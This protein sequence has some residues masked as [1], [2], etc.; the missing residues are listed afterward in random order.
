MPRLPRPGGR[1]DTVISSAI[2]RKAGAATLPGVGSPSPVMK[3]VS[4]LKGRLLATKVSSCLSPC[5]T[6][7]ATLIM[8]RLINY[9]VGLPTLP[10]KLG[11]YRPLSYYGVAMAGGADWPPAAHSAQVLPLWRALPVEQIER[12]PRAVRIS[13]CLV[14]PA[15]FKLGFR[16]T[17]PELQRTVAGMSVNARTLMGR[18]PSCRAPSS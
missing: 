14:P 3:I 12:S 2:C 13:S 15:W 9:T 10:T 1:N 5:I 7:I 6:V 16:R 17:R 8:A 18:R 11:Y 4:L